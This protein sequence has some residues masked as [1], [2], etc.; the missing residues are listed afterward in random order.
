MVGVAAKMECCNEEY[1]ENTGVNGAL[2]NVHTD[3]NVKASDR[4]HRETCCMEAQVYAGLVRQQETTFHVSDGELDY[5]SAVLAREAL[6]E[7][8]LG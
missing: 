8:Q 7:E 6:A 3:P 4:R 1:F 5:A 2:Y